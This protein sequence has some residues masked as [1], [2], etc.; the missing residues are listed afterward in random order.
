MVVGANFSER[1]QL[2]K[3]KA[4][5]VFF[6]RSLSAE[7]SSIK[8]AAW[9][10]KKKLVLELQ[11]ECGSTCPSS[12]INIAA[13]KKSGKK[14]DLGDWS[15]SAGWLDSISHGCASIKARKR[16]ALIAIFFGVEYRMH[17]G[18]D[19]RSGKAKR[20]RC[21]S[22][23]RGRSAASKMMGSSSFGKESF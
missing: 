19:N 16:R 20:N 21:C 9:R 7:S 6:F 17:A 3:C 18:T 15:W 11:H 1:S 14:R 2:D 13:R 4:K 5:R 12:L 22:R 23:G 8:R 10:R